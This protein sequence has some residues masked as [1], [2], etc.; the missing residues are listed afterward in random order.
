MSEDLNSQDRPR[1][2]TKKAAFWGRIETLVDRV[3][4]LD[5][6]LAKTASQSTV[7]QR[8]RERYNLMLPV[9]QGYIPWVQQ[10]ARMQGKQI[11]V[12]VNVSKS[13][14]VPPTIL[15]A[16]QRLLYHLLQNAITHGIEKPSDRAL[17]DKGPIG[18]IEISFEQLVDS[19]VLTICDDGIGLNSQLVTEQQQS[20]GYTS[21]T[22]LLEQLAEGNN[23][24]AG[25]GL[26]MIDR[27]PSLGV[28][29][30]IVQQWVD[31]LDGRLQIHAKPHVETIVEIT[32]PRLV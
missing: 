10:L 11:D 21:T 23:A 1:Q 30:F 2:S 29:M 6:Q 12:V 16:S 4:H 31:E 22:A 15:K 28:G 7:T 25:A 5:S 9:I 13:A 32:F 17:L 3:F 19:Y 14:E 27:E 24:D 20:K 26:Q 18:K 8:Q